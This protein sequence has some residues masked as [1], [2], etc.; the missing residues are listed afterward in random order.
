MYS[1]F[2]EFSSI[3]NFFITNKWAEKNIILIVKS[4]KTN[5]MPIP[6]AEMQKILKY[7]KIKN[8]QQYHLVYF[9]LLTGMRPSSAVKI[10]WENIFFDQGYLKVENVKGKKDYYFPLHNELK[11][12]LLEM[13]CSFKIIF[14]CSSLKS[15]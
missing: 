12:L 5:T 8:L 7:Y 3:L 13:N 15:L 1:L 2:Q 14:F 6:Y 10:S 4:T 11:K 9:L